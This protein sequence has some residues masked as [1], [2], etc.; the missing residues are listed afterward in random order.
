[1][2]GEKREGGDVSGFAPDTIMIPAR[3]RKMVDE[4]RTFCEEIVNS[5]EGKRP[6]HR[7][8]AGEMKTLRLGRRASFLRKER[9]RRLS[10]LVP[11]TIMIPDPA[12]EMLDD[13]RTFCE[14]IVNVV[15]KL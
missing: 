7:R 12:G 5:Q 15:K 11:D 2:F 13:L 9:G 6:A 14:E 4:L 10:G 1:M 3:P 8:G